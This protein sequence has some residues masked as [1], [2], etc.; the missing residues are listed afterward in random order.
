MVP[1]ADDT[2]QAWFEVDADPGVC[3][4]SEGESVVDHRQSGANRS[5]PSVRARD[6]RA[7]HAR[8]RSFGT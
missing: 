3:V 8:Q 5:P 4:G 1:Q 7:T 2:V 6:V